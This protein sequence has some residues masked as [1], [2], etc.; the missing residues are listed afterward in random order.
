M[1]QAKR[2]GERLGCADLGVQVELRVPLN[3]HF[4]LPKYVPALTTQV[5]HVCIKLH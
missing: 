2:I 1:N 4:G 5:W 3:G